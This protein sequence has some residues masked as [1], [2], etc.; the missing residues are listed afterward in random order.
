MRFIHAAGDHGDAASGLSGGR[1]AG[2]FQI[3]ADGQ[4]RLDAAAKGLVEVVAADPA[5]LAISYRATAGAAPAGERVARLS[6]SE[7]VEVCARVLWRNAG[8]RRRRLALLRSR[9]GSGP[10]TSLLDPLT[11]ATRCPDLFWALYESSR[12]SETEAEGG[13][14]G[15]G[16]SGEGSSR[17]AGDVRFA[18]DHV[19][20]AAV[21][22][23]EEL[24][25]EE[26]KGPKL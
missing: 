8:S 7:A 21:A 23:F 15:G 3:A 20:G 22:R 5:R 18:L 26:E 1:L 25:E 4:R 10:S 13:G 9:G 24:V 2:H 11:I 16:S 6:P 12:P 19:T 17:G 14:G